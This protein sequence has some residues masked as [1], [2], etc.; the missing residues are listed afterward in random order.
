MSTQPVDII[1][2][3]SGTLVEGVLDDELTSLV[4]VD[5]ERIWGPARLGAVERLLKGEIT[6]DDLP[7]H[8]HWNWGLKAL[9]L[10]GLDK[11][12]FG[13][14]Y[15]DAWQGLMLFSTALH[16]AQLPPDKGKHL[17]YVDYLETAPWNL[18]PFV[19]EPKFGLIGTRLMESAVR[20]SAAE[21]F[22]GR[23]GLHSLPND[24]T[25]RFYSEVCGMT[26]VRCDRREG[27]LPYYELTTEHALE[28]LEEEG[29]DD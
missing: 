8:T 24:A 22:K 19:A 1:E 26:L 9:Q 2:K 28:F 16:R 6:E 11:R 17:L 4:L 7:Q 29:F 3:S 15:D 14:R 23:V 12:G 18:K 25:Q 27:N 5:A 10:R 21:G 20:Q 13:I